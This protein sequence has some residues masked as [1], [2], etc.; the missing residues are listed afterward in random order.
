MGCFQNIEGVE[1]SINRCGESWHRLV[2][3]IVLCLAGV[4]LVA[5]ISASGA[6]KREEEVGIGVHRNSTTVEDQAGDQGEQPAVPFVA[7][8]QL[9]ILLAGI[10]RGKDGGRCRHATAGQEEVPGQR[11]RQQRADL[12]ASQREK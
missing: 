6:D 12:A 9:R 11:G 1:I 3:M 7:C 4:Y 8:V 5:G 10:E 2:D